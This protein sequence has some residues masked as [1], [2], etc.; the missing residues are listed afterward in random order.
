MAAPPSDGLGALL[1]LPADLL[2]QTTALLGKVGIDLAPLTLQVFLLALVVALLVPTVRKLRA[3]KKA[4]RAPLINVVVLS[5]VAAGVLIGMLEN[6]TTP[7]TVRGTLTSDRL[8]SVQIALL[9]FRDQVISFGDGR[10]DTQSGMFVLHYKPLV[11]SRARK[12]RI[13]SAGCKPQEATLARAQL[14]A[15]TRLSLNHACIPG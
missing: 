6:A 5:L 12:V 15:E 10:P 13:S 2:D 14:R 9:D 4:D 1:K 8:H 11:D 3:R 7:S